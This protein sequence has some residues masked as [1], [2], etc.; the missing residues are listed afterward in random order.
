M[1]YRDQSKTNID[2]KNTYFLWSKLF[3]TSEGVYFEDKQ[4]SQL[5]SVRK[6]LVQTGSFL[7]SIQLFLSDGL[8]SYYTDKH[9]SDRGIRYEFNVPIGEVITEIELFV[10]GKVDSI[11]FITD[12]RTRSQSYGK[13][14][15]FGIKHR[16]TFPN[17]GQLA[18]LAGRASNMRIETLKFMT[19]NRNY[20]N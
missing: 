15:I 6:V 1:I 14:S 12:K 17:C 7:F 8:N 3:G 9:G 11:T 5:M 13:K 2:W 19:M 20:Y 16:V 10:S 18:G 4:P